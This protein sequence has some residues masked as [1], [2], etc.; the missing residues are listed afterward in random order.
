[1]DRLIRLIT[2]VS[3]ELL[4]LN[5]CLSGFN[6]AGTCITKPAHKCSNAEN[7]KERLY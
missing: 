6:I 3:M 1:M 4:S 2:Q 7:K 5:W